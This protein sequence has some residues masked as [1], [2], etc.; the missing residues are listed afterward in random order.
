MSSVVAALD[1]NAFNFETGENG[2]LQHTWGN[3]IKALIV[4]LN[5]QLVRTNNS[6]TQADI[7][8]KI[9]Q[10][11]YLQDGIPFIRLKDSD[12]RER[13]D[14][15]VI[16]HKLVAFTRD[17][18]KGKGE[19]MLSFAMVNRIAKYNEVVAIELIRLFVND[20]TWC[21]ES[22]SL[23]SWKD[24]KYMWN[25]F[26][27]SKS[28]QAFFIHLV[29]EQLWTDH[30]NLVNGKPISLVSKWIPREKS[31][32]KDLFYILAES[33]YPYTSTAKNSGTL[34]LA[35]KKS[36]K[37]YR[38]LISFLNRKLDTTQIKQCSGKY[39]G[40]NFKTVTGITHAK[41]KSA[42]L[43]IKKGAGG[44]MVLRSN[45]EDRICCSENYKEYMKDLSKNNKNIKGKRVG[46]VDMVKNSLMTIDTDGKAVIN[47][48]ANDI[49][50]N[51]G[52]LENFIAMVDTSG[53]MRGDPLYAA[54]GLGICIANKS[55]LGKRV[56][57]FD[58]EPAWINLEHE[59]GFCS[60]VKTINSSVWGLNTNFTSALL[61][62]LSSC[63]E[64]KLTEEQ[65]S[66]LVLVIL[67]DMQ[68][69]SPGN[70]KLNEPMWQHIKRLYANHGYRFIPHILFWNLRHTS[71]FPVSV[72][73]TGATMFSGFSPSLLSVFTEKG[74]DAIKNANPWNTLMELLANNRYSS[75]KNIEI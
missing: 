25:N 3:D 69:D 60:Q 14:M 48:Q 6:T 74:M 5:Y 61:K 35:K 71:G 36:Y 12:Y 30:V 73:Q 52:S 45:E 34:I 47:S 10:Q 23:G 27:W 72:E 66:N 24:I 68:I 9:Y 75:I 7:F 28:M 54:I 39:S 59:H 50:N 58:S 67:S 1:A 4:Q 46:I 17:I 40:I 57:T 65:V 18:I 32:Y 22:H 44:K 16:L 70:E 29:N 38:K 8:E 37:D 19:Y 20:L 31:K 53:S 55:K 26:N 13:K 51:L 15:L 63:V 41:Q 49:M 64:K 42:F 11:V 2:N 62:I 33:Y 56:L 43:N 21:E